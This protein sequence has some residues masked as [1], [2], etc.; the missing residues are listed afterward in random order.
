[1]DLVLEGADIV[2]DVREAACGE[3]GIAFGCEDVL[4]PAL[5][6]FNLA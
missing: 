3:N 4:I 5:V 1:M 6:K 2:N